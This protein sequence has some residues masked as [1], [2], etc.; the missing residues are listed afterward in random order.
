ML[1]HVFKTEESLVYAFDHESRLTL[2]NPQNVNQGLPELPEPISR[3]D[4]RITARQLRQSK[5]AAPPT[6]IA[7]DP[8][9]N[10]LY[11]V[12]T[13]HR[14]TTYDAA[15]VWIAVWQE[16]TG[17]LDFQVFIEDTE[18]KQW[19]GFYPISGLR[20]ARNGGVVIYAADGRQQLFH[21]Q[22]LNDLSA[23]QWRQATAQ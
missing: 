3:M 9:G 4:Y 11:S 18:G 2:L 12:N 20:L 22:W 8:R 19:N 5:V 7:Y 14:Y 1:V 17:F 6:L 16:D 10:R 13:V 15:K 23:S 21:Y